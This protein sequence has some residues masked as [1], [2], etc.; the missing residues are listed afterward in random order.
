MI[1]KAT[2]PVSRS[3][4]ESDA[5]LLDGMLAQALD[6]LCVGLVLV[7]AAGRVVW[8]NRAAALTLGF[9]GRNPRGAPL[10]DALQDEQLARFWQEACTRDETA[11]ADV[12]IHQ[13]RT[14]ALKVNATLCRDPAGKMIGRAM[15]FC[16]VTNE[17]TIQLSLTQQVATRLLDITNEPGS[18]ETP[19]GL[20]AREA[21]VLALV[22]QGL[23][24]EVIARELHIAP[25]TLRTHLKH[26]YRKLNLASRAEAVHYALRHARC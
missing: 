10:V 5:A 26:L 2:D 1:R 23:S 3:T 9:H 20:T 22:G 17:R 19:D 24:N 14:A 13:P 15:M 21:R 4:A 16:D 7:N 18:D 8:Y 11:M 12:S 25:S 6:G